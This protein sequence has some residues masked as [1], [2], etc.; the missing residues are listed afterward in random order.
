ML[1]FVHVVDYKKSFKNRAAQLTKLKL[2]YFVPMPTFL[3]YLWTWSLFLFFKTNILIFQF[4]LNT[5]TPQ[6]LNG[7]K[8]L[9]GLITWLLFFMIFL[10]KIMFKSYNIDIIP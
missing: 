10:P 3:T 8:S 9:C 4:L 5:W 2:I 1:Q 7:D 6:V